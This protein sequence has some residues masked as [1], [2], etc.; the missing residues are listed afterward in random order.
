MFYLNN[1]NNNQ[2]QENPFWISLSDLMTGLMLVFIVISIV[3]IVIAQSNLSKL[4]EKKEELERKNQQIEKLLKDLNSKMKNV[5]IVLEKELKKNKINVKYNKEKGTIEIANNILFDFRSSEV[6]ED[7]KIFL[8]YHDQKIV[9]VFD[10][11]WRYQF[12]IGE[13]Y[14]SGNDNYHFNAPTI[15]TSSADGRIFVVIQIIIE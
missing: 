9:K 14:K 7:G 13:R 12:T 8:T 10:S 4:Q 5:I 6:K 2:Q 3:F 1:N 15:A 11:L